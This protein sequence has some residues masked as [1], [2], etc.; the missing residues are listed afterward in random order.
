MSEM[1]PS[2]V[3]SELPIWPVSHCREFALK[4]VSPDHMPGII[5]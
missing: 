3:D 5:I 2:T 1:A 4:P